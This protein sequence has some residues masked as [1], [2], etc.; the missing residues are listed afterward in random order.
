MLFL[1]GVYIGGMSESATSFRWA[2]APTR[3]ELTHTI[4]Q[5]IARCRQT[6]A[7]GRHGAQIGGGDYSLA[8]A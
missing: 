6:R 7:T 3:D 5:R 4:A 1:D 2:K 8:C